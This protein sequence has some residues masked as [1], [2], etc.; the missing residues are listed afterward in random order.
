MASLSVILEGEEEVWLDIIDG[1]DGED[2]CVRRRVV[3]C[4]GD[5]SVGLFEGVA[6]PWVFVFEVEG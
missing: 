6:A 5:L 2:C 3:N 1:R 4:I